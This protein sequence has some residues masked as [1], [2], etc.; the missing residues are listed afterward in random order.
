MTKTTLITLA[1]IADNITCAGYRADVCNIDTSQAP[2]R[3]ALVLECDDG[4]SYTFPD[5]EVE[6]LDNGEV[7]A[8]SD[9]DSEDDGQSIQY[10]LRMTVERPLSCEDLA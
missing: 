1:R 3:Y 4:V 6:L 7:L 10:R 2:T 5:Q 9:A 8:W